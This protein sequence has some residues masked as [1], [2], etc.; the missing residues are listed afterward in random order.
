[1]TVAEGGG[2]R[3]V[4]RKLQDV[5]LPA[6]KA[7]YML[8]PL[9]QMLNFRVIPIQFQIVS[10]LLTLKPYRNTHLMSSLSF[11]RLV[12]LGQ[13]TFLSRTQPTKN[14]ISTNS[15]VIMLSWRSIEDS[16]CYFILSSFSHNGR[17]V[18]IELINAFQGAIVLAV[19]HSVKSYQ[20]RSGW[21]TGSAI[22]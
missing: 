19:E 5:Y 12:S 20:T 9:V 1:M 15:A 17:I 21:L 13:H 6:L 11:P 16:G 8:W 18:V 14:E 4:V 3:A 7:N 10:S 22:L 2:K